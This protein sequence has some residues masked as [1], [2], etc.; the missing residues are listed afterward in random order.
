MRSPG[1]QRLRAGQRLL[2]QV[3]AV[4][5]AEILDHDHVSLARDPRVARGGER[6]LELDLDVS[7][8]ERSA[9]ASG[10]RR[11]RTRGRRRA[12]RAAA[13]RTRPS[14]PPRP[15]AAA[16]MPG[17]VGVAARGPARRRAAARPRRRSRSALHATHSRNRY[18]TAR[19]PNLRP[20][21][22]GSSIVPSY[23]SSNVITDVP[24]SISSPGLRTSG[25]SIR[26]PLRQRAVGRAEVGQHPRA[27]A[28][29]D[30]GVLAR[31]VRVV[32]HDVALA[33]APERR[34]RPGRRPA[35]CRRSAAAPSARGR[36]RAPR[37]ARRPARR[38]CRSSS[39]PTPRPAAPARARAR[40]W[41]TRVWIPNS[42][43][44]S[45]SSVSNS[46]TGRDSSAS[47]SRRA[48][49]SRYP[50]S[51]L[52]QRV[53][54]VGE[55]LAVTRREEHAVLVGHVRA[56]DREGLVLL[57]LARQLARDL[58]RAH[59]GAKGT[60]ERAFDEAGDLAFEASENTHGL[61]RRRRVPCYGSPARARRWRAT[62][63]SE[64]PPARARR[65]RRRP[66]RATALGGVASPA[67]RAARSRRRR[68]P[69]RPSPTQT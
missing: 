24:S 3:G 37:A 5:G 48:C 42:P 44:P 12:R 14:T 63:A 22:T 43:S 53:L 39:G 58:D 11:C 54:V 40:G 18:R 31:D 68:S 46:I 35:A 66:R 56:R 67:P 26:R 10:R 25:P 32:E 9:A 36:A 1:V 2:V 62:P 64:R 4:G 61:G 38:C 59:L 17:R 52:G 15:S 23:S 27:A 13:A 57:H 55:P 47:R 19:K 69:R 41:T 50:A 21:E 60:A 16:Y 28:R 51:S 6:V 8:A 49:S 33:A 20:T 30:L 29:A 7:A 34:R 65:A 45:R